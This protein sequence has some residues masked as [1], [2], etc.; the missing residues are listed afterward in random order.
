MRHGQAVFVL[1]RWDQG[2]SVGEATRDEAQARHLCEGVC[3]SPRGCMCLVKRRREFSAPAASGL[4][5][6]NVASTAPIGAAKAV[7]ARKL[8]QQ[9]SP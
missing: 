9:Q 2:G 7:V 6:L 8:R 5:R 3:I 1:C 4:L